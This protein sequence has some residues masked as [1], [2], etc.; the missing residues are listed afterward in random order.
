MSATKKLTQLALVAG[1]L[2]SLASCTNEDLM[3]NPQLEAYTRAFI[4]EFGKIDPQQDWNMAQDANVV[5]DLGNRIAQSV[6]V[7]A[8]YENTYYIVANLVDLTGQFTVPIDIPQSSNEILV[9]VDGDA[10]YGTISAPIDC[11]GASSDLPRSRALLDENGKDIVKV[12][13]SNDPLIEANGGTK[14]VVTHTSTDRI[15]Q[16]EVNMNDWEYFNA[17]QMAPITST[18]NWP[19]YYSTSGSSWRNNPIGFNIDN[20][21]LGRGIVPENG[22]MNAA[23]GEWPDSEG[24]TTGTFNHDFVILVEDGYFDLYPYYSGSNKKH[25]LYVYFVNSNGNASEIDS[26]TGKP[27]L[28]PIYEDTHGDDIQMAIR[29]LTNVDDILGIAVYAHNNSADLKDANGV[30][31]PTDSYGRIG[32]KLGE[33]YCDGTSGTWVWD[34]T[35]EKYVADT[36]Q[37]FLLGINTLYWIFPIIQTKDSSGTIGRVS[38]DR[39]IESTMLPRY[40]L[41]WEYWNYDPSNKDN[42][43]NGNDPL[44][45]VDY[46]S[47]MKISK[48]GLAKVYQEAEFNMKISVRTF[49][50]T[51]NL[52]DISTSKGTIHGVYKSGTYRQKDGKENGV[53]RTVNIKTVKEPLPQNNFTA[54]ISKI[55]KGLW[56]DDYKEYWESESNQGLTFYNYPT[57]QEKFLEALKNEFNKENGLDLS[58][59]KY[60]DY[61]DKEGDMEL[62]YYEDGYKRV[63]N[64]VPTYPTYEISSAKFNTV[65]QWH[66]EVEINFVYK[67]SS[68]MPQRKSRTEDSGEGIYNTDFIEAI[69]NKENYHDYNFIAINTDYNNLRSVGEEC[70][71]YITEVPMLCRT[72]GYHVVLKNKDGSKYTGY[73]GIA[74]DNTYVKN[75]DSGGTDYEDENTEWH[76]FTTYSQSRYNEYYYDNNIY[77]YSFAGW[78][79]HPI[80]GRTFFSFEDWEIT[81]P[82][83]DTS[84][85]GF[86]PTNPY[87]PYDWSGHYGD[88]SSDRDYNDL[89][90][91]LTPAVF[92]SD[93]DPSSDTEYSDVGFSW[94][95]ALEDLGSTD[96]FDFNDVVIRIQSIT[97][98][99]SETVE[100]SDTPQQVISK[101]VKLTPL[102][103]GGTLPIYIHY[104]DKDGNDYVLS[105][106]KYNLTLEADINLLKNKNGEEYH[107]WFTH[108]SDYPTIPSS[109]MINTGNGISLD[110]PIDVDNMSCTLTLSTTFTIAW[111]SGSLTDANPVG[112]ANN[113]NTFYVTVNGETADTSYE[114][115]DVNMAYRIGTPL[116][117]GAPQSFIIMETSDNPWK[118][119]QERIHISR[120]YPEFADWAAQKDGHTGWYKEPKDE[121]VYSRKFTSN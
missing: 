76:T 48:R 42:G 26:E 52:E 25:D 71:S 113:Q 92:V 34:S 21:K 65:E 57:T 16:V 7:Y 59:M 112:D 111:H 11:T 24:S 85:N 39:L 33:I 79:N 115:I 106:G 99:T 54:M 104:V 60:N 53:R 70:S 43:D 114:K 28:Y 101:K 83:G 36:N 108:G 117:G 103:A 105:T 107:E 45:N 47:Y 29:P 4:K 82:V 67:G 78:F 51:G 10:Y 109:Q 80:S 73:V 40:E 98:N 22:T 116:R 63:Y 56:C 75:P 77:Q 23:Y 61:G 15:Y 121:P 50:N 32:N 49:D 72:H 62:Y 41:K 44:N 35:Q 17:Q 68:Q 100:G 2:S 74:L 87:T 55:P 66:F 12:T 84:T 3:Y 8:R 14:T 97:T 13:G 95:W 9:N 38:L 91:R 94:I 27:V 93:P 37:P 20:L 19:R 86:T 6:K 118:W 69:L 120:P 89:I 64:S 88:Y 110:I 102:A 5:I 1:I 46:N 30:S 119:P 81:K 58:K 31:Y 18:E 96:D 90:F